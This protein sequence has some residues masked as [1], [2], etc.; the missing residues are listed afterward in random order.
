[1]DADCH[2][3]DHHWAGGGLCVRCG[4]RLRCCYCGRFVTEDGT[5]EHVRTS[6]PSVGVAQ[7]AERH[8]ANVE[9]VGSKPT[10]HLA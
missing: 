4:K 1:M 2:Y 9:V 10:A 7:Q 5:E 3:G 8:V 6:C